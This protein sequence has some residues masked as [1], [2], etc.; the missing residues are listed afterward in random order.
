[1][2]QHGKVRI[3]SSAGQGMVEYVLIIV[4]VA[5]FLFAVFTFL[6]GGLTNVLNNLIEF[7]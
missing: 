2:D 4:L 3:R 6:S 7:L 1:M 5:L